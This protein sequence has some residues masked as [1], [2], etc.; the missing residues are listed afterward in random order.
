MLLSK[1]DFKNAEQ[2]GSREKKQCFYCLAE[3]HT[4]NRCKER[5]LCEGCG[6]QDHPYIRCEQRDQICSQ[7]QVVGHGA[8]V[9]ETTDRLLRKQLYDKHPDSFAHFFE[10]SSHGR[11]KDLFKI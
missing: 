6:T 3:G 11:H 7:C 2:G 4:A 10:V 1:Q 5:R 9:H 8:K